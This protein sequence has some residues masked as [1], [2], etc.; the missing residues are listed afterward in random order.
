MLE[1]AERTTLNQSI[2]LPEDSPARTS[3]AEKSLVQ[4]SDLP[5]SE[6]AYGLNSCESFASYDR[7]TSSWKTYMPCLFGEWEPFSEGWPE[8]GTMRNGQCYE[9]V[10]LAATSAD[11]GC[12]LLPTQAAREGRDWSQARIL[13][14]LDRGDGVAKRIC[15]LR[16][17]ELD[18]CLIVGQHP[19]YAEER[20]GF[21]IGYSVL[22]ES[23]T[24][25]CRMS[26]NGSDSKLSKEKNKMTNLKLVLRT[27]SAL[28]Q[29]SPD[30]I[31]LLEV[32]RA[33]NDN[34]RELL[35]ET[36]AGKPVGKKAGKKSS[37]KK[38]ERASGMAAQLKER[39]GQ[40]EVVTTKDDNYNDGDD[41]LCTRMIG[42]EEGLEPCERPA[43]HNIHHLKL[44]PGYHEFQPG[45]ST[46]PPAP[47][48]SPANGAASVTERNTR[49]SA[50]PS[51]PESDDEEGQSA[52]SSAVNS[53]AS[54]ASAQ[55]AMGGSGE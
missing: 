45:K 26:Q 40:R 30:D 34:D 1:N 25:S 37:S 2:S 7:A 10:T 23:E 32:L 19:S 21:P 48:P 31:A 8:S 4:D 33:L 38:S 53:E 18:P 51:T 12:L 22:R 54:A 14:S 39:R 50:P 24:Q 27:Y 43:D 13:A 3:A 16:I 9:V 28:R 36:M 6:A 5:D 20:M 49:R 46:A 29:M 11:D 52:S 15:R 47:V 42:G 41:E 35:L 55:A 44:H 17:G